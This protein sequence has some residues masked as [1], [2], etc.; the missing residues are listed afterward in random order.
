MIN[1]RILTSLY[2]IPSVINLLPFT[3][4]GHDQLASQASNNGG[5]SKRTSSTIRSSPRILTEKG[6]AAWRCLY[7]HARIGMQRYTN[8]LDAHTLR[9]TRASTTGSPSTP[10]NTKRPVIHAMR[11]ASRS[12]VEGL[13]ETHQTVSPARRRLAPKIASAAALSL[14]LGSKRRQGNERALFHRF[15]FLFPHFCCTFQRRP[16][17]TPKTVR[18]ACLGRPRLFAECSSG[19]WHG[20]DPRRSQGGG[21]WYYCR[22]EMQPYALP[23][24]EGLPNR[25]VRFGRVTN[26]LRGAIAFSG[27]DTSIPSR[28]LRAQ[29]P[30]DGAAG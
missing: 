23:A 3:S 14:A 20:R 30:P 16:C 28:Y 18:G 4:G 17:L 15:P 9:T 21:R 10:S 1:S 29:Y 26:S 8:S 19:T 24:L 11:A 22:T 5:S 25:L 13:R 7:L 2:T 12:V 6:P 27:R